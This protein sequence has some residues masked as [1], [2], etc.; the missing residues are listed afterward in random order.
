[1]RKLLS[2]LL[3]IAILLGFSACGN[4]GSENQPLQT[5]Q[6]AL[7]G[8]AQ[9]SAACYGFVFQSVKL[10]PG[11]NLAAEKLPQPHYTYTKP[12]DVPGSMDI[13]YNYKDIEVIVYDNG[14]ASVIR[15]VV[16]ISPALKTPEGLALG[17][18]LERVVRLYG[19]NY[20]HDGDI[21]LFSSGKTALAVLTQDGFVAGIEYR[22]TD[23]S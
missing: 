9:N 21:W 3:A 4:G 2:V 18:P 20:R 7:S 15:S 19:N 14:E 10:I 12:N 13:F 5:T 23:I 22:L 8:D 16:V 1:M 17:D 6:N 11:D